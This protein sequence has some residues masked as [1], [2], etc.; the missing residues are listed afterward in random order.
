MTAKTTAKTTVTFQLVGYD[1]RSERIVYR[2][3]IP[4]HILPVVKDI[5]QV[6]HVGDAELGDCELNA[7][8]ALDIAGLLTQKIDTGAMDFFLE[9][10]VYA[11]DV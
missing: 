7:G 4:P 8:Q 10:Y 2:Q 1:K 9:P 5:A 6:P 11:R 3:D